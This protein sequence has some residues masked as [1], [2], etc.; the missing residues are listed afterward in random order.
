MSSSPAARWVLPAAAC[1][2]LS[3]PRRLRAND[4][5]RPVSQPSL[6]AVPCCPRSPNHASSPSLAF[7]A[8]LSHSISLGAGSE[9]TGMS[10][11]ALHAVPP[12]PPVRSLVAAEAPPNGRP[13]ASTPTSPAAAAEP[14]S[15]VTLQP[16]P[17]SQ[18]AA[19]EEAAASGG[20]WSPGQGGSSLPLHPRAEDRGAEDAVNCISR[21]P[22]ALGA[23]TPGGAGTW[24][25]LPR[26]AGGGR[27]ARRRHSSPFLA[28][29][30]SDVDVFCPDRYSLWTQERGGE[31]GGSSS[32]PPRPASA[33][34]ARGRPASA[35]AREPPRWQAFATTLEDAELG[36][37]QEVVEGTSAAVA[38]S[39]GRRLRHAFSRCAAVALICGSL[40]ARAV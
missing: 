8:S 11:G 33:G 4:N 9:H 27:R 39:G 14:G 22:A 26:H 30:C 12:G 25:G 10:S 15:P 1:C 36:M 2:R 23:A 29:D 20:W 34:A 31:D 18:H 21:R 24:A 6:A 19:A 40:A 3:M 16:P 7:S 37:G 35:G 28:R 17:E 5:K 38:A 13:G 32:T